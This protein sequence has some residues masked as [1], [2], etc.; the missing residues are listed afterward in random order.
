MKVL[1]IALKDLLRSSRSA[2]FWAFG[3]SV[4]FLTAVLLYFAFGGT[5][6]G[7]GGF[8]LPTTRVQILNLDMD[9]IQTGGFS[10]GETLVEFLQSESLGDLLEVT[11]VEDAAAARAAVDSREAGVAVIIPE[12]FTTTAF[13][14]EGRAAIEVYQDPTLTL[15][16][17]IVKGIV[18]QYAD[19]FAG[20]KIAAGVTRIN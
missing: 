6:V 16:P 14:T 1:D 4:P 17:G 3:F 20:S 18:S 10:A 13:G 9:T 15:G 7:E 12:A 2:A 8:D 11:E 19:G 5:G